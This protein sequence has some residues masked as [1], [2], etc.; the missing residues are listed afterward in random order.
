MTVTAPN[1]ALVSA[2][3]AAEADYVPSNPSS[4]AAFQAASS[5][6]PGGGTRATLS[7]SP[8]PIY[9]ASA[10]GSR[11]TSVDGKEYKDL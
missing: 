6:L 2:L 1:E 8:F 4:Q 7:A 5:S 11:L 10:Q 3:S 9:I